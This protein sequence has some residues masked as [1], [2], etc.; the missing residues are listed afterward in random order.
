MRN[1]LREKFSDRNAFFEMVKVYNNTVHSA[2]QNKFTPTEMQENF[3]R[4]MAYI[5]TK[6]KEL[7][8][9]RWMQTWKG[10]LS[11]Y[12]GGNI[13][14]IHIPY[15]KTR[16]R[17][18]KQRRNFSTLAH[19]VQYEGGNAHVKL[20]KPMMGLV[21]AGK[22]TQFLVIPLYYTKFVAKNEEELEEKYKSLT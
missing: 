13:L 8:D 9:A 17:F 19:F 15:E 14:L 11:H 10:N 7:E 6:E 2:F 5:K 18:Q 1:L 20:F 21:T 4:E 22:L 12:E 16:K 3:E